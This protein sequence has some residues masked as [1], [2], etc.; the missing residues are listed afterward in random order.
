MNERQTSLLVLFINEPD[1]LFTSK[2]LAVKFQ[3]CEKTIR[4]D[5]E[6]VNKWLFAHAYQIEIIGERGRG[7][8]LEQSGDDTQRALEQIALNAPRTLSHVELF[9]NGML[10]L[11][12]SDKHHTIASLASRL[13]VS[14]SVLVRELKRWDS[15]LETH[16]LTL[17][18]GRWLHIK[19]PEERIRIFFVSHL[20]LLAPDATRRNIAPSMLGEFRKQIE[21]ALG[22]IIPRADQCSRNALEQTALLYACA[23]KRCSLGFPIK[24]SCIHNL[25]PHP[26][27]HALESCRRAQK[28]HELPWNEYLFI[29]ACSEGAAVPWTSDILHTYQPMHDIAQTMA[30]CLASELQRL[31]AAV[32]AERQLGIEIVIDRAL[33]HMEA[34]V[35]VVD[36]D[37]NAIRARLLEAHAALMHI[38]I[39]N[40]LWR[41]H[42]LYGEDYTRITMLC[43]EQLGPL[44]RNPIPRAGLVVNSGLAVAMYVQTRLQRLFAGRIRF[45]KTVAEWQIDRLKSDEIDFLI[46]LDFLETDIGYVR[47]T[48]LVDASDVEMIN[49]QIARLEK[50]R[51]RECNAY[52][53]MPGRR[54]SA[55]DGSRLKTQLYQSATANDIWVGNVGEYRRAITAS[56]FVWHEQALA[57]IFCDN[58]A[59]TAMTDH[60]LQSPVFI[61]GD[62]V[63]RVKIL[64][65]RGDER[66]CEC[67]AAIHA[68]IT[69]AGLPES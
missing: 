34:H 68:F 12:F 18:R 10:E 36:L 26:P 21:H 1:S 25:N 17:L 53:T 29:M 5:I 56:W 59:K 67:A 60:P 31:G 23:I 35:P 49:R 44:M 13:F 11:L 22:L 61:R 50:Q 9:I 39:D 42:P 65:I 47:I 16:G 51:I 41:E 15:M 48:S 27:A 37:G 64:Y 58:V 45:V 2:H 38:A 28:I 62:E 33:K 3:C 19:G 57:V 6:T 46:S 66:Q 8:H 52:E 20:Y 32:P 63:K 4:T 43:A 30:D 69:A 24:D 54:L 7:F 40:Q 55:R 14:R